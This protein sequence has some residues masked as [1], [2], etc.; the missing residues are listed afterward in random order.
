M[1]TVELLL[2]STN[3]F[4]VVLLRVTGIFLTTPVFSSQT[5]PRKVK[6]AIILVVS[7]V[8]FPPLAA[9]GKLPTVRNFTG[10]IV[11]GSGE[12]LIGLVIGFMVLIV[13]TVF[14]VSGQFYSIQMGFGIIN[15]FDPLAETSVPIISQFKSLL[16]TIVFLML[17]GH[18]FVLKAVFES[19]DLLPTIYQADM[20]VLAWTMVKQFDQMFHMGF[21][22]GVPLIG[23]VFLMTMTLGLLSKLSPQM[24]VMMLGFGLKVLIGIFTFVA[25]V[26]VFMDVATV[27]FDRIFNDLYVLLEAM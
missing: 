1:G 7:L 3:K 4:L 18:H 21:L 9:G 23:I 27:L 19:Y 6:G 14:Q 13:I 17:N 16:M 2:G 22:I 12:L 25:L 26:P 5:I 24:N 11:V 15:V 20:E 8:A 10:L